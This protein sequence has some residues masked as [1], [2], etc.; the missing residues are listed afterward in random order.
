MIDVFRK[1]PEVERE[2][3]LPNID[4]SRYSERQRRCGSEGSGS[5]PGLYP[6]RPRLR[7]PIW[8]V[9]E[10]RADKCKSGHPRGLRKVC[11]TRDLILLTANFF[12]FERAGF[13]L[14][15][16]RACCSPTR[17][18]GSSSVAREIT[19]WL[20]NGLDG[21]RSGVW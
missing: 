21:R 3:Q 11:P 5:T 15:T 6:L 4:K 10:Y 8:K 7:I 20:D 16:P 12:G 19:D 14:V 2:T 13:L 17:L 18:I 1:E 9:K